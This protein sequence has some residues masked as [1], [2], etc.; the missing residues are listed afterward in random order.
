MDITFWGTRGSIPSP[1]PPKE[2]KQKLVHVLMETDGR[3]FK[4]EA[5][6]KAFLDTLP[7][8]DWGT[9]GGNTSCVEI[10][11]GGKQIVLDAGSGLRE[12]GRKMM[13][14]GF[15]E[16]TPPIDI[17]ISHTHWDHI[18]A[19]P[20]FTPNFI[21]GATIN[22]HGCHDELETRF[23]NQ[24]HPHNFPVLF[25]ELQASI[26]FE[27][28]TPEQETAIAGFTVSAKKVA[29]PGDSYAYRVEKDDCA[30]IYATDASYNDLT[31]EAMGAYH[32][33]YSDA[34]V[35]IFDAFFDNLIES[36]QKSEYGHSSSFIGVDIALN[37]DVKKLV[38]YHHDHLSNDELLQ[39][40]VDST[41]NYLN[42]VA[43]DA[44][45]EVILA[46]EGLTL[47]I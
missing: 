11:S 27:Q 25:D 19:F 44:D 8:L 22:I 47:S 39:R 15:V 20:L 12:L 13:A 46:Q 10:T 37:A 31:P 41:H 9:A 43:P 3:K 7:A 14:E 35:L 33:F 28:L 17:L 30:V 18:C 2:L 45:C 16:N 42:H 34:D 23:R 36:F 6:A 5:E 26:S 29:H 38:L 32:E 1:L 4:S 24:H 21:P 40:M